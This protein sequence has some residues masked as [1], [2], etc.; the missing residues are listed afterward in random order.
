[1]RGGYL[2][3]VKG[4]RLVNEAL[5][6]LKLRPVAEATDV[7]AVKI[8]ADSRP[9]LKKK[10]SKEAR[11]GGCDDKAVILERSKIRVL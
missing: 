6:S 2:A 5:L 9:G 7:A 1:M 4:A 10:N 11:S 3:V 8:V